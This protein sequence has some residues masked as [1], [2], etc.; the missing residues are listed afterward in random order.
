[1]DDR[2]KK[3]FSTPS[4]LSTPESGGTELLSCPGV[5]FSKENFGRRPRT[6][7]VD[8]NC[9]SNGMAASAVP[10]IKDA[11]F[12]GYE[13]AVLVQGLYDLQPSVRAHSTCVVQRG[14][15]FPHCSK[16][17]YLDVIAR[18]VNLTCALGRAGESP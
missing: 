18:Q 5:G 4:M 3:A 16:I 8:R 14:G 10:P 13:A 2:G 6:T 1:M 17:L 9:A 7:A 11:T 15:Q 12:K